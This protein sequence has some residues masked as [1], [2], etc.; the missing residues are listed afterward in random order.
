MV[1]PVDH[2]EL[3][4]AIRSAG[5]FGWERL[6]I[7]DRAAAWF[8]CDRITRSESRGAARRGRNPIRVV[9]APPNGRYAFDEVCVLT[10]KEAG[11]PLHR[12]RLA[13]GA[14]QLIAIPDES[15]VDCREEDWRRLAREVTFVRLDVPHQPYVY[16]YR[17]IATIALAEIARQIGRKAPSGVGRRARPTPY[18]DRALETLSDTQGETVFLEDLASY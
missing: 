16:H 3:G 6:L 9:A 5:A 15:A 17:L 2:I 18:Y 1:G 4:S 11:T 12:A 7:E 14:R 8:G 13:G 10:V